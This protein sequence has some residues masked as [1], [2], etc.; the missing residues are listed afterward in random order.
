MAERDW[1]TKNPGPAVYSSCDNYR[2][3]LERFLGEGPVVA[4]ILMNPSTATEYKDDQTV[5]MVQTVCK[6]F[7]IGR[8]I[9][10]NLYA[11]RTK[12]VVNL[13]SQADP[14]GPNNDMHLR[15]IAKD[16]DQVIVAWGSPSK[17]PENM[18]KRWRDVV[19]ILDE[20]GK[21]LYCLQHIANS[22]PRHPQ[23]LKHDTPLPLWQRP[24]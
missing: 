3:R 24:L 21:P 5:L 1:T 13:K 12:S 20:V 14:I 8:A 19:G 6:R 15:Q 17:V 18:R 2:Y 22:H 4:F 9:I 16:A 23:I 7:N 11:Y 10:G